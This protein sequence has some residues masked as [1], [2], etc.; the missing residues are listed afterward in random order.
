M[1]TLVSAPNT[2]G[3]SKPIMFSNTIPECLRL[4]DGRGLPCVHLTHDSGS[5]SDRSPKQEKKAWKKV[6]PRS[7]PSVASHHYGPYPVPADVQPSQRSRVPSR[8]GVVPMEGEG[9]QIRPRHTATRLPCYCAE[10][11][12]AA[13]P[14]DQTRNR[15]PDMPRGPVEA[16]DAG[17][18]TRPPQDLALC[19]ADTPSSTAPID[20]AN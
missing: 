11:H 19:S 12:D 3:P 8:V 6:P 17:A 15:C 9:T 1:S 7:L 20:Q 4:A 2:P 14:A 10:N 5:G 13:F 18:P 16:L